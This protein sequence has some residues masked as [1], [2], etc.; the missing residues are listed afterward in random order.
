MMIRPSIRTYERSSSKSPRPT[1]GRIYEIIKPSDMAPPKRVYRPVTDQESYFHMLHKNY[2]YYGVS[3]KRVDELEKLLPKYVHKKKEKIIPE[4]HVEYLDRVVLQYKYT[5]DGVKIRLVPCLADI[6]E[7][8]YKHYKIPNLDNLC[9]AF[10]KHGYSK[11]FIMNMLES[12]EKR[13]DRCKKFEI[14][15]DKIFNKVPVKKKKEEKKPQEEEEPDEEEEEEVEE[16]HEDGTFEI[17][18]D[19]E[20]VEEEYF[21]DGADE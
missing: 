4:C 7:S 6:Y 16:E 5:E 14:T 18:Q 8:H 19:E 21:S 12:D 15:F 9:V 11:E 10:R 17:E 13:K 1:E 20:D 2:A 3:Q